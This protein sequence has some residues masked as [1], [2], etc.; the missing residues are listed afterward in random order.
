MQ[1][2]VTF[3]EG[4]VSFLSP[5]MLPMLPV[6]IMYF[7]GKQNSRAHTLA[8]A[9]MFVLGFTLIFT[10]MGVFAGTLGSLLTAHALLIKILSG[11]V[12][13]FLGLSYLGIFQL[14][15]LKG[16]AGEVRI[17]GL[18]SSFLFGIVYAVSLTPC[19]GVFLGSALMMASVS[20]SAVKGAVLL[21]LY[22]SGLGLPFLLSAVLIEELEHSFDFIKKHYEIINKICGILLILTGIGLMIFL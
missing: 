8:N 1:Y 12:I 6:Y 10:A 19:I 9:G 3:L 17:T 11:C 15:F 21:V 4:I 2:L 16:Y 14:T 13:I 22:S 20:A 5:C 18:L 7:S